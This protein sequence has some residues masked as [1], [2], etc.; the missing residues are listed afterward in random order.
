MYC[1]KLESNDFLTMARRQ[2]D[3]NENLNFS[4][5]RYEIMSVKLIFEDTSHCAYIN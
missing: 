3:G 1:K 5:E 2:N 4:T